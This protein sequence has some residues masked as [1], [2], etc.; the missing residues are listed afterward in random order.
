MKYL[1]NKEERSAERMKLSDKYYSRIDICCAVI[2]AFVTYLLAEFHLTNICFWGD[3][4]AAY[5]SEGIAI[6]NDTLDEQLGLNA[7]MHP[8]YLPEHLRNGSYA[9]VWGYPLL[10]AF[11]YRFVGFDRVAFTSVI[12]YKLP[13][14]YCL[15]LLA[16]VMFLYYRRYLSSKLSFVLAAFFAW[17]EGF[18]EF[19]DTL[20][21]DIVFLAF[22]MLSLLLIECFVDE[23][24]NAKRVVL[25]AFAGLA[26][27]YTYEVRLNGIAILLAAALCQMIDVFPRRSE[28]TV[29]KVLEE[30]LPYFVFGISVLVSSLI[31][32]TPPKDSGISLW[33]FAENLKYYLDLLIDWLGLL[34]VNPV[35]AVWS[36]FAGVDYDALVDAKTIIGYVALIICAVGMLTAKRSK[37]LHLVVLAAV[38]YLAVCLLPYQQGDRYIYPLFPIVL[39]Y[40]GLG[41]AAIIKCMHLDRSCMSVRVAELV[42]CAICCIVAV[43]P[44]YKADMLIA[45]GEKPQPMVGMMGMYRYDIYSQTP[46]EVYNYI[47]DELPEDCV[48]GFYKPRALYLNTERVSVS[49]GVNGHTAEETDYCLSYMDNM[50]NLGDAFELVFENRDFKLYKNTLK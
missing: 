12:Y 22:F 3:D 14:V 35:Y 25:G 43:L 28:L 17:Y 9:Y 45:R 20:Y 29:K 10:L 33:M 49:V 16:A 8:S 18:Y 4:F 27:W 30:L 24:K 46:V 39:L 23:K 41:V 34:V 21:S 11:I 1:P 15:A 44:T 19:I 13:S 50:S 31:M 47:R 38:Y 32:P 2:L 26:M 42:I 48:I 6:A 37:T 5:I 36:S 40:F 7:I